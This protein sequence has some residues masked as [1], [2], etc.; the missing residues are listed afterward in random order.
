VGYDG[1]ISIEHED[2]LMSTKQGLEK[3]V[4]FLKDVLITEAAGEAYW[5]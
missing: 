1:V 5:F 3:A 4:A 2:S